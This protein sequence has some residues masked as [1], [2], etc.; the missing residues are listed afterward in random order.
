MRTEKQS[1]FRLGIMLR[2]TLLSW[3]VTIVTLI[4]FISIIIPDQKQAF[5]DNMVSKAKGV[6]VSLQDVA[7]SAVITEDYS[8]VIDH[9]LTMLRGDTSVRFLI[10]T[11]N[12][13]FSLIHFQ[14]NQWRNEMLDD[15]W[16][17][18]E[19]VASSLIEPVL[20]EEE[21]FHYIVPFD[22]SGIQWGWIHIGLSLKPYRENVNTLYKRTAYL[23][24]ICVLFGLLAS[25]IYARQITRPILKLREAV[26]GVAEGD[27][28]I[29]APIQSNDEVGVLAYSFN[30]MTDSLLQRDQKLQSVRYIAQQF[31]RSSDWQ[32][33]LQDVLSNLGNSLNVHA[34]MILK[35]NGKAGPSTSYSILH[36]WHDRSSDFNSCIL[37]QETEHQLEESDVEYIVVHTHTQDTNAAQPQYPMLVARLKVFNKNWGM[38]VFV[39]TTKDHVW[40]EAEIDCILTSADSLGSA[41]ER[42]DAEDA[43]V[44]AK[45][46]AEAASQAKS[47]FLAN[48][49]HEIRTPITG[50][51]GML[52]LLKFTELNPTQLQ[53][54]HSARSAADTLLTVIGD[55]LDF[56]KIEAGKLELEEKEISLHEIIDDVVQLFAGKAHGKNVELIY[57][58]DENI[59]DILLGDINRIRQIL[60]NLIGNA[61]KFTDHGEIVIHCKL[62]SN[63]RDPYPR[64]YCSIKD[65]GCGI[66]EEDIQRI[67][68]SFTQAD[69]SMKRI[70]GGTGLG[71]PI[72]RQLCEM[73]NGELGVN[74]EINRGS[75]FWF[76]LQLKYSLQHQPSTPDNP[77]QLSGMKVLLVDDNSTHLDILGNTLHQWGANV[78]TAQTVSKGIEMLR[79]AVNELDPYHVLMVDAV[80]PELG[81]EEM[82]KLIYDRQEFDRLHKILMTNVNEDFARLEENGFVQNRIMKPLKKNTLEFLFRNISIPIMISASNTLQKEVKDSIKDT[83]TEQ[84]KILIVEDQE[85]VRTV[86]KE[87]L[88]FKGYSCAIAHNGQEAVLAV[89]QHRYDLVL[90][91]CQMPVMDG[92]EATRQIRDIGMDSNQTGSPSDIP[93]VALT[94]HASNEDRQK[95]LDAGMNDYL[96]KPV[97]PDILIAK[98][99]EWI[100]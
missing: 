41:I 75:K 57:K 11:R 31:L 56:S 62:H 66:A 78:D 94:A 99:N 96:S 38:L 42:K 85:I 48:M 22:Y 63:P 3:L 9:C 89:R 19:R 14:P 46:D 67:F 18:Q 5:F 74:S 54:V 71:L 55:V 81:G 87:M 4:I 10:L 91:D 60:F 20:D 34:I 12:D 16:R 79:Q 51:M 86:L 98:I 23:T 92:Y 35:E 6:S 7:A 72:S 17:P 88:S 61:I 44:V 28:S 8:S 95:C 53:Y 40:S 64:I 15:S 30:Q 43:L 76:T 26:L 52:D 93:I 2:T 70:Y 58:V 21:V 100:V 36:E 80:M 1:L 69:N 47:Q 49:S 32:D 25:F 39:P 77:I 82:V 27:L 45:N 65:T 73:M 83:P 90:M 97:T 59:P 50:V 68:Q 24:V 29:R 37:P 84:A 33:C 13:G